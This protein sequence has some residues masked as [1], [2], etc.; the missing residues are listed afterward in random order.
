MLTSEIGNFLIQSVEVK[1]LAKASYLGLTHFIQAVKTAY[2]LFYNN[3]LKNLIKSINQREFRPKTLEQKKILQKYIRL[4]QQLFLLALG[5]C[6]ATCSFWSI[7]PL[8]QEKNG[9]RPLALWYPFD[10]KHSPVFEIVYI[11]EVLSL[12]LNAWANA[13]GDLLVSGNAQKCYSIVQIEIIKTD[14]RLTV[15]SNHYRFNL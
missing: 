13:A 9:K 3:H 6:L 4:C 5:A 14:F 7:D 12:I 11:Y 2:I 10:T 8:I 1:Q 15:A